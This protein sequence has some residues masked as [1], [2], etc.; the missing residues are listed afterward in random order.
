MY[1]IFNDQPWWASA[2]MGSIFLLRMKFT[3]ILLLTA[4]VQVNAAT[5]AQTINLKVKNAAIEKVFK[6]LREQSKYNFYYENDMISKANPITLSAVN[7]PFLS[8]LEKCFKNQPFTYV[9]NHNTVVVRKKASPVTPV[10]QADITVTGRVLDENNKPIPGVSVKLKGTTL[11]VATSPEGDFTLKVPENGVLVFSYIGYDSQEV[12][13]QG[14]KNI[15]INLKPADNK[16]DDVVVVAYGQK[17]RKIET[18]GAQSTLNVEDLKQPVANIS[19][20]LAGRVS[21]LVGVQRSGEPGR[22]GADLW[23]RGVI[24]TGNNAPLILVDGVERAFGNIDPN[25]IESF[26]I[27][28]DASSTSVYGV[29]GANGV[30]LIS[31]KRGKAGRTD[32][33]LDY[34]QGLTNFTRVPETADGVTYMQMAN[35]AR[36]TRGGAPRYTLEQISKTASGEDPYLY[37]NVNWFDEIF[38]D[39]GKNRK[40]NLSIRGGNEK[41]TFYVSAGYYDETGLFK[42]DGLQQYNSS[43]KFSRINFSSALTLKATKTTTVDLG[44]K[45]WIS[46]G[47]YPGKTANEIFISSLSTYPVLY[48]VMYPD[49]KEPFLSTGGGLNSAYALLTNRGYQT[50]YEN[51]I[52]SDIRVNQDMSGILKGLSAHVLYSFDATNSNTLSRLKT[53]TTYYATSRDA[54][55]ELVYGTINQGQD[56]LAFSRA[57]GGSRQFYLEGAVKYNEIFGDHRVGGMLLYYQS[58][59]VSATAGDLIGSIPYRSLGGVGRFNYSY[60][61]RYLAELTFGYNGAE[62]FA[63]SKRYGFFPSYALGWVLSNESFYGNAANIFQLVKLRASCG[64]VG[65]SNIGGR[66]FSYIGTVEN[67][68]S[69]YQF[70]Q[71]R[72]NNAIQGIDIADY[73]VDATW[74]TEKDL[75]LGLELKT[76][77]N[78]LGLQIDVFTRKRE[79]IFRDRGVVPSFLGIRK[80][81]LGN[82]GI[83]EARG[84]DFTGNYD[85]RFGDFSLSFQGTFTYNK[86]KIIEDDS[87]IP[88]YPWQQSRGQSVYNRK[89]YI[90]QG[91]YTQAEIDDSSVARTAGIVQAG[92]LKFKD[93]NGDGVINVDDQTFIGKDQVPQ[94]LYGF[95]TTVAYKGF[96]LGAFFQ[97]AASVDF[98]FAGDF[99][100]FRNGDAKGSL[101]S[102]IQ[103]RW[104]PE[105]PNQNAFYPR[106]TYGADINQNYASSS[107]FLMNGRFLRLKTLDFGYTF[108]KESIR[109]AGMQKLR[110]YFIGYNLFTI[111]P[112]KFWDP[113]LGGGG[114]STGGSGTRYPNIKTFSLGLSATF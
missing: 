58:D 97:G 78:A 90:A 85:K 2:R 91:F 6:S 101:Y 27:L 64:V 110:L 37:P 26:S 30:V 31:T 88:E 68:G 62:N 66:R 113:E 33:N 29:R 74:E 7:E 55:G 96:S 75:N 71:A 80:N 98:Y 111:S 12:A 61:D 43:I 5:Y 76:L 39:F 48:P 16:L 45:G 102:N 1:K 59:R 92:D 4:I 15:Q 52:M 99:M 83:T 86:N 21:G 51:Q 81:L 56:Y 73:A 9:I 19:T 108:K 69:A 22:D 18:L 67:T 107:H 38:N 41:S 28:K 104:T 17:Q 50:T 25:D 63:P 65:S 3:I 60:K 77:N 87:V 54:N 44:I 53:P 20:V 106:L 34:Y 82:L 114:V 8:V 105:N 14:R 94:M 79:N 72:G 109:F 11:T 36:T 103:D 13:V 10:L 47:N 112:F 84:I 70:G 32:I 35:E 24:S 57:N 89:G 23:I 42:A 95:G 49:N 93:L 100:P 40:A 46:N